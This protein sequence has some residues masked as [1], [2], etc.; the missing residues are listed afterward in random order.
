ML[1]SLL[2]RQ[3]WEKRVSYQEYLIIT[4]DMWIWC[5]HISNVRKINDGNWHGN[6]HSSNNCTMVYHNWESIKTQQN[7]IIFLPH[8][9]GGSQ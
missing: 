1:C 6:R 4:C 5:F 8:S 3:M 2:P 9:W 7:V